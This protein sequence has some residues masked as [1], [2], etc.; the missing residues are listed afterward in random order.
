MK[1]K[2]ILL[3]DYVLDFLRKK[4]VKHVPLLIGGA[5]SFMVDSF[6]KKKKIKY[7]PVANEQSA[8]MIADAYSRSGAG[9]CCTMATSGP[10]ATN[11]LTGIA[12]SYFDSVPSM[13]ICGQVN[14]YEQQGYE[15][16]TRKVRQVGFQE[17]D[18]VNMSKP[19]TKFSYKIKKPEEI[20]FILE[21]AY[22]ISKSGRPGPVLID[23]PMNLQKSWIYPNKIKKFKIPNKNN[24]NLNDIVNKLGK[25]LK[26]S[27]KPIIILGGGVRYS[28]SDRMLKDFLKKFQIPIVATWSGTDLIDHNDKRYIGN[29]GVYGNRSANIIT[30]N[31]DLI[32]CLG[33]RLDTRVTGGNP[34][35]F[36]KKAKKIVIDVDKY[37]LL[38]KRGLKIDLKINSDLKIFFNN[39]KK[40]KINLIRKNWLDKSI[41]LKKQF[42]YS[43]NNNN[44]NNNKVNPYMFVLELSKILN[45][46]SIIIGDTGSHLTW[47]MQ[48][49]KIKYGQMLFSAFGNS[50]MGYALPASI[51]AQII[52]KKKKIVSLNGDGSI[53][54]NIQEL[55]TIK[56]LKLPVKIIIFNNNGYGII[57]QFQDLYLN[58]RHEASDRIVSN[59]N[60]KILSKGYGINYHLIQNNKNLSKLKK[61]IR[62]NKS[63]II[64]VNI[65]DNE[66]IIPK[67]EFGK[68][69]DDLSPKI[70]LVKIAKYLS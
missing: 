29:I 12:C 19:I 64:E 50:P 1:N 57:K 10:G 62:S 6:S 69:I 34:G 56:K 59:P 60:F 9:Y 31:S 28:N 55:Q 15:K 25:L 36:A 45:K 27:K 53:Q 42:C 66:K 16:S 33:S 3:A 26:K 35:S 7:I 44:N 46:N 39:F 67:L 41:N 38:K 54:L 24:Y 13:H 47:L 2:K 37:E 4:N 63:E 48:S 65:E 68:P 70:D 40:N 11:L 20:R 49:F 58:K 51:G 43:N 23:I 18:I 22:Y 17:T 32:I 30:Q 52:N 5:I 8:A 61:I 21:K 14:T